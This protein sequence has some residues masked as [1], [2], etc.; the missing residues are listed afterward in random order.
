[1]RGHIL[2]WICIHCLPPT[3]IGTASE[4]NSIEMIPNYWTF[5]PDCFF[6]ITDWVSEMHSTWRIDCFSFANW[7]RNHE[8]SLSFTIYRSIWILLAIAQHSA[9]DIIHKILKKVQIICAAN[10]FDFHG[11]TACTHVFCLC[12]NICD[13]MNNGKRKLFRQYTHTNRFM[14]KRF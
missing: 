8:K 7:R 1:M 9:Q 6:P 14:R 11:R 12:V 3:A 13:A 4:F 2:L 10:D 5:N